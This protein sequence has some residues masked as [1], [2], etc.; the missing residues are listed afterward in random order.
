MSETKSYEDVFEDNRERIEGDVEDIPVV[1][2][3]SNV[4]FNVSPNYKGKNPKSPEE[5]A[6]MYEERK[7]KR[8][9]KRVKGYESK[10]EMVTH[11]KHYQVGK[12][13]AL[14]IIKEATKDMNGVY[15]IDTS[16]AL[17]Y[18]LRWNK[19]GKPKQDIEKAI[20]YL[21]DLVNELEGQETKNKE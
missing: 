20:F 17:K 7:A 6:K 11:P 1:K 4:P 2:V 12:Y 8:E 19:K 15:A 10:D 16:Q 3:S 13:E 18:I 21:T 9:A 5:L 14:D